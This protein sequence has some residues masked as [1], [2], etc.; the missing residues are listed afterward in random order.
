MIFGSP[1]F[2]LMFYLHSFNFLFCQLGLRIGLTHIIIL[3]IFLWQLYPD[4]LTHN[5]GILGIK[6]VALWLLMWATNASSFYLRHRL[7]EKGWVFLHLLVEEL[8]FLP[9]LFKAFHK[10]LLGD[11]AYV[12][13]IASFDHDFV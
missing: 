11:F 6:I 4:I 8:Q 9:G 2:V 5:Y 10:V 12:N 7:L 13:G 3:I 1:H